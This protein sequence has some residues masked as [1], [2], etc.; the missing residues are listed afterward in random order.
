MKQYK[1]ND[2]VVFHIDGPIKYQVARNYLRNLHNNNSLIFNQLGVNKET[3]C[4]QAYR[5]E[6][7][8]GDCPIYNDRD[9]AAASRLIEAL[10]V[11]C[12]E[13]RLRIAKERY[14]IGTKYIC[15]DS[16]AYSISYEYTIHKQSFSIPDEYQVYGEDGKGCLYHDGKWAE[17][18]SKPDSIPTPE[19]PEP[20]FKVGDKVLITKGH[21]NWS[22][23]M[24]QYCGKIATLTSTIPTGSF[25]IDIDKGYW[26]WNY[27]DGHFV[28]A[29]TLVAEDLTGEFVKRNDGEIDKISSVFTEDGVKLYHLV[30]CGKKVPID[31]F[32]LLPKFTGKYK[33]GDRVTLTKRYR[34]VSPQEVNIKQVNKD[35]YVLCDWHGNFPEAIL[36][37]IP[38]IVESV[39][40]TPTSTYVTSP[41]LPKHKFK[42]GDRVEV[43]NSGSGVGKVQLGSVVEIVELGTYCSE[44]G[45]RVSPLIGNSESGGYD[46]MIGECSFIRTL[47]DAPLKVID[48]DEPDELE[49][50]TPMSSKTV[51]G[52]PVI[53]KVKFTRI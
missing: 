53:K 29:P 13:E 43:V 3:F 47:D 15:A 41:T 50:V 9:Y 12:G 11:K 4:T 8:S 2:E 32:T 19:E 22:I 35:S 39:T 21:K 38:K 46:Y 45:Y 20:M 28:K 25:K 1:E 10:H 7:G 17:I 36:E 14:P 51:I 31:Q 48:H 16:N 23:Q 24:N 18:L 44:P 27:G 6:A 49:T 33:V 42:V 52:S 34:E 37:S 30:G 26:H 5:Y 40:E